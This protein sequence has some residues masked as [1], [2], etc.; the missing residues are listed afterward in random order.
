MNKTT[1]YYVVG[2]VL[3]SPDSPY[4][5]YEPEWVH[6]A[7]TWED[8]LQIFLE[9]IH[10]DGAY[11]AKR[12]HVIWNIK[13]REGKVLMEGHGFISDEVETKEVTS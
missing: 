1:R 11:A 9:K 10:Q 2:Y 8:A 5:K 13:G 7:P 6:P 3:K 12:D 4:E